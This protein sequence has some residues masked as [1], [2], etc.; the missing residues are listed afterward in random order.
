MNNAD[1]K[2][3]LSDCEDHPTSVVSI[4]TKE[5][6]VRWARTFGVSEIVLVKA[7]GLVGSSVADLRDLFC[8]D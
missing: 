5:D 1:R 3:P 4:H 7:V 6:R 8:P 2:S